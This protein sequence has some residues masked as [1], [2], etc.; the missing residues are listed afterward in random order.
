MI[1]RTLIIGRW[2][3]DF[4]FAEKG[5]DIHGVVA[6]LYDC[7]ATSLIIRR[8][9]DLMMDCDYNCGFTF[10]NPDRKRAVVLIGPTTSGK[11][12]VD[13]L[14]HE[15]HHLAVSIAAELGVD[16]EGESPAY[17]AGDSAR[18]LAEVVCEL[19]CPC[20]HDDK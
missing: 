1:K 11:E 7:G 14:T 10:T 12:F 18:A 2:V 20:C 6:G 9:V 17:I 5:Y 4:Y 15:I 16:L 13:T 19:G 3:V 8:A